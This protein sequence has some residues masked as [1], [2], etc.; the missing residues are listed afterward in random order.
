MPTWCP[1]GLC[2][3]SPRDGCGFGGRDSLTGPLTLVF[4]LQ[5]EPWALPRECCGWD[6]LPFPEHH[7]L[8]PH[9]CACAERHM[10]VL[11]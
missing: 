5:E 8:L 9:G 7:A 3:V 10:N 1:V 11:I 6:E 2:W 4:P